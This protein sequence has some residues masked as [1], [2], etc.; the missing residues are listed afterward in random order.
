MLQTVTISQF[1]KFL[2]KLII[3]ITQ[4]AVQNKF[5]P[6]KIVENRPFFATIPEIPRKIL[7]KRRDFV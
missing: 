2:E 6:Q 7:Q 3:M 1:V 4:Y 5:F